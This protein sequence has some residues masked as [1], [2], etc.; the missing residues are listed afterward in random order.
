M[1]GF[2][3][4]M[5]PKRSSRMTACNI[6]TF[7]QLSPKVT[8]TQDV[9][10]R[11]ARVEPFRRCVRYHASVTPPTACCRLHVSHSF[12]L[13]L[14]SFIEV[15]TP[16]KKFLAHGVDDILKVKPVLLSVLVD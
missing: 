9:L 16:L 12:N 7:R 15:A 4:E 3:G 14:V 1:Q 10:T 6:R 2:L 5:T 13:L 8:M 11:A